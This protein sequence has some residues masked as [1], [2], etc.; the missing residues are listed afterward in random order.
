MSNNK[1]KLYTFQDRLDR[2]QELLQWGNEDEA[3]KLIY[4][5]VKQ[6]TVNLEQFKILCWNLLGD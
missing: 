5:W 3:I 2:V 1:N 6:D 4:D